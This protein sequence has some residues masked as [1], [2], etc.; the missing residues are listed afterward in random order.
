MGGIEL[1]DTAQGLADG[2]CEHG[3]EPLLSM[4]CGEFN[5]QLSDY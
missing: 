2:S 5:Y 1:S 3:K 4:N